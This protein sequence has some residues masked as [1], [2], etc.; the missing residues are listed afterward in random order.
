MALSARL[1]LRQS[2][3]LVMTPQLQQAIKLLQFNNLELTEF[4]EA[5]LEQN[6][7]L[8]RDDGD[9]PATLE[10]LEADNLAAYDK[11]VEGEGAAPEGAGDSGWDDAPDGPDIVDRTTSES[12]PAGGEDPGDSD[13]ENNWGSAGVEET[14]PS[15]T[16]T[17]GSWEAAAGSG[18]GRGGDD[19]PGIE[20]SV[21][22]LKTLREHL[23]EQITLDISRPDERIIAADLLDQLDDAGYLTGDLEEVADRLGAELEAVETVLGKLQAL[24]PPGIFARSL[25]ECLALQLKDRNRLDPAIQALLDNLPLLAKRDMPALLKVCGV[26]AEDLTEMVEEIR[27]LNPKPGLTFE[28]DNSEPVVPDV[29]VRA[30]PDGSWVVELNPDTLPRVLVNNAYLSQI[31]RTPKNKADREYLSE[32][33]QSANWLVRSLH[34]RATTI[35]KV[36]GEIVRQ[37]DAFFQHGIQYLRP[38]VLRDI[39][40]AIEMHESTVS[41]VTSNKFMATPRG[42]Y[43][44]KYF[45][46]SAIASSAGGDALSAEAVRFKIKK[47]IDEEPPNKVL[48]DDRIVEIL[49]GEGVDIARRTIAKYREAMRIPSSVQRR[50]EKSMGI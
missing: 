35:L 48:S 30:A 18:S 19:L 15:V 27:S 24:D 39:A 14:D 47:L 36:S 44:L 22:G 34:Q 28:P 4:V 50:R 33:H 40:E 41:R 5:E 9:G 38:L 49:R 32:C 29:L 10:A 26:D 16:P 17:L 23:L 1:D 42:I 45:F 25:S 6:P 3:N 21:G 43:E 2:Q 20:E 12:L 7:L 31:S 46:T 37:Q 8:E 13:Y 11:A